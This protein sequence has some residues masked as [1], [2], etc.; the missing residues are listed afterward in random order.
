MS[1]N[2]HLLTYVQ[3]RTDRAARLATSTNMFA[4]RH[5]EAVNLHPVLLREHSFEC[6][7]RVLWGAPLYIPPAVG[8]TVDVNVDANTW[9]LTPNAQHEVGAFGTNA[10]ERT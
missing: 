7:H 3:Y 10:S 9:L 4:K 8:D 6:R 1:L 5:Q 2:T